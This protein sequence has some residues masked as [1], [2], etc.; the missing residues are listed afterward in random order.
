[1][2]AIARRVA[3]ACGFLTGRI[4]SPTLLR[5]IDLVLKQYPGARWHS[6]EPVGDEAER[7][8]A[9]LA[10]GRPLQP[11]PRLD[12]GQVVLSLDADPLGPGPDQIRSARAW[13][14]GRKPFEGDASSSRL[15]VVEAATTLTGVKADQRLMLHPRLIQNAAIAV[16]N[17]LGARLPRP[18]LPP[19]AT[20]FLEACVQDL[21]AHRGRSLVLAGRALSPETHALVHWINAELE[22]ASG[23]VELAE[24]LF[25]TSEPLKVLVQ[26]LDA[27]RVQSPS[28]SSG[29]NPAYDAPGDFELQGA[30]KKAPFSVH[31]GG[32]VDETASVCR[33]HVPE[34]HSLESWSDLRAVDGTASL[35]QPLIRPLYATRTAHELLASLIGRNNATTFRACARDLGPRLAWPISRVGG[36]RP[37]TT[38]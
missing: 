20:G 2:S 14:E 13:I 9:T 16:A 11:L 25:G 21:T 7:T 38:V 28:S 32:Y 30:L 33:W 26:D 10:F 19:E 1:M 31:L 8:G 23:L 35:M 29:A 36:V 17:A 18:D 3:R 12:R 5:Q 6:Y 34:S 37:S 15:Y 4:T 27:G 22:G 24:T